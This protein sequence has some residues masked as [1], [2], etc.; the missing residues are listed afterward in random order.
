TPLADE[1]LGDRGV[2]VVPDILA[3]AGGVIVSYFEWVQNSQEIRWDLEDVNR[4]LE[5]R[6]VR[7]YD[8]CRQFQ[9][10][11]AGQAAAW[12]NSRLSLR[13]AAYSLAV[14]RVT[15]AAALRGYL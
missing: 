5:R 9:E 3:N 15:E 14:E 6:L 12:G 4:Q 2:V 1:V 11:H 13:E 10:E 8:Q 7:A